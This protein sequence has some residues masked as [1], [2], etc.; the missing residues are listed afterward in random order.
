LATVTVYH[1]RRQ[2]CPCRSC[3]GHIK[4]Y[5]TVIDHLLSPPP[6]RTA[7]AATK[8]NRAHEDSSRARSRPHPNDYQFSGKHYPLS[9]GA[10]RKLRACT[11]LVYALGMA[12]NNQRDR[13]RLQTLH[14][15]NLGTRVV[16]VSENDHSIGTQWHLPC[17]FSGQR[18]QRALAA[19]ITAGKIAFPRAHIVVV[20]DYFW[21]PTDYYAQRYGTRWLSS[22]AN[23]YLEAG[24][25]EVL[26]PFD[27][28][29]K[30]K[31]GK[32]G[33]VSM[34]AAQRHPNIEIN[35]IP[36][37]AHLLWVATEK[38]NSLGALDRF[39]G[40]SNAQQTRDW[41]HPIHPF[42]RCTALTRV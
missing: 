30:I 38:A 15:S 9:Q 6:A 25:A 4:S 42:V 40:G 13:L 26:L 1:G 28:G 3:L 2:P 33:M 41:L 10:G 31:H 17:D 24:A 27:N 19:S 20:L 32:S 12:H 5:Q 36:C 35:Y 39:A 14:N 34:L 8:R 21:L 7:T 23:I 11:T 18:G 37:R 29:S 16:T 22:G